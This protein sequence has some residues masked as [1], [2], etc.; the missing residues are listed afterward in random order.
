ME[1]QLMLEMLKLVEIL[2]RRYI[3]GDRKRL[4]EEYR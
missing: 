4:V 3:G 2:L 1:L